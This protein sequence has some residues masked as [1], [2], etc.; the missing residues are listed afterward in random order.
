[1]ILLL[2]FVEDIISSVE[3]TFVYNYYVVNTFE[4]ERNLLTGHFLSVCKNP[5]LPLKSFIDISSTNIA[6]QW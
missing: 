5:F 6:I 4:V 1:V 3:I 2:F